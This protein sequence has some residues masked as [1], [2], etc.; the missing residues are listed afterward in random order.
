MFISVDILLEIK[1][2]IKSYHGHVLWKYL[3]TLLML[4]PI[5][6]PT[7][8]LTMNFVPVIDDGQKIVFVI[9][10]EIS[11]I[12]YDMVQKKSM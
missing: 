12:F 2:A 11:N 4:V 1:F 3:A 8:K 9:M 5:C 7:R 6:I 10:P